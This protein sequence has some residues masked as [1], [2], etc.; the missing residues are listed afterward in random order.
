MI[1]I[2][3]QTDYAFR[4]VLALA[5]QPPGSRLSTSEICKQMLI[6]RAMLQR[7]VA[8][9]AQGD[10]VETYPGRGGGIQLAR[11][12]IEINMLQV[13]E[14]FEGPINLSDCFIED[15]RCPFEN[16]CS[17]RKRIRSV[18]NTIRNLFER[19]NFKDLA[20]DSSSIDL[21]YPEV[22]SEGELSV[23]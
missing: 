5:S 11:P 2:N 4:V 17:V 12:A 20:A 13:L 7:I 9:L 19:V 22:I 1:R 16:K 14:H 21:L 3:R 8:D 15:N 18:Q 6:P 23:F 10:F